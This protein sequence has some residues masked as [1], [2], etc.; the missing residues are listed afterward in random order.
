MN[1]TSL[2][3]CSVTPFR[4]NITAIIS[5]CMAS[6]T[7]YHQFVGSSYSSPQRHIHWKRG[8]AVPKQS[9]VSKIQ[10]RETGPWRTAIS[11]F[12]VE[13]ISLLNAPSGPS[14]GR[15]AGTRCHLANNAG[16]DKLLH[17]LS[18]GP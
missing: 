13:I 4:T 2:A 5:H 9:P 14:S 3:F 1:K 10:K 16:A 17:R 7:I 15:L 6:L 18:A 12:C 11:E 8:R